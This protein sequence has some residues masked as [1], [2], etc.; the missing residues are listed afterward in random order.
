MLHQLKLSS[1]SCSYTD[2][3]LL[4][5]ISI[6]FRQKDQLLLVAL[7]LV[8]LEDKG[9]VDVHFCWSHL[10]LLE[11][12]KPRKQNPIGV[13]SKSLISTAITKREMGDLEILFSTVKLSLGKRSHTLHC[14]C[15]MSHTLYCLCSIG[16]GSHTLY[17]CDYKPNQLVGTRLQHT[18]KLISFLNL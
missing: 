12:K 2:L 7:E 11:R 17:A 16:K 18:Q 8:A 4:W 15:S 14:L 6:G 9:D 10:A 3:E 1:F 5:N 13:F